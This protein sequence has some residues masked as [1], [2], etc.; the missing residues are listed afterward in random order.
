MPA[1]EVAA[2][3][4]RTQEER[5]T[6][7]QA[8]LLQAAR[9]A[10]Y[11]L[12]YT[13][14][15]V[16]EIAKRAGVSRGA[17][18]HHFPSK[19]QLMLAVADF[20]FSEVEDEVSEIAARLAGAPGESVDVETFIGDLWTR[21]FRPEHFRPVMEMI[22]AARLDPALR[23]LLAQRWERMIANYEE[24]WHQMLHR[25]PRQNGEMAAI[26]K[27]TLSLLRGMAFERTIHDPTPG[28][29]DDLLGAW[30]VIVKGILRKELAS[31]TG[32]G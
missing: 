19:E 3:R 10:I 8:A 1:S 21:V 15:T 7:T 29:Y 2:T 32:S 6:A 18:L 24:I 13:G 14:A 28:Y 16:A 25:S 11:E 5:S 12:G 27:L 22:N 30:A 17:Q 23:E 9:E 26:L 4:R 20:I 31:E